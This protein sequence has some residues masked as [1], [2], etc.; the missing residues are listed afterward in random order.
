VLEQTAQAVAALAGCETD[1]LVAWLGPC[2]GPSHFEV[3]EEVLHAFGADANAPGPCFRFR[4]RRDGSPAW[5]GDLQ[6]LARTRLQTL[7]LSQI[8]AL[9]AC[10]VEG[11]NEWF[12]YR[13]ERVTG[14][15]AAA[16]WL[17]A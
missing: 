10:T 1:G 15:M 5:L 3:G 13:R 12:S 7:K 14:R 6:G 9:A 17:Q 4:A 8:D 11:R 2:I 16:V